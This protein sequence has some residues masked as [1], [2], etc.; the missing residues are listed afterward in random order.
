MDWVGLVTGVFGGIAIIASAVYVGW[1]KSKDETISA[2]QGTIDA[3]E[4]R[5]TTVEGELVDER[6]RCDSEIADLRGRVD[7]LSTQ[8]TD[9]LTAALAPKIVQGLAQEILNLN[10]PSN[11]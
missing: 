8:Q 7:L 11:A 10:P 5:V 6:R 4:R 9:V 3:L 1:N 2:Q